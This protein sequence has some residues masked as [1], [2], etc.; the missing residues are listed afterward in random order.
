MLQ[1]PSLMYLWCCFSNKH[2]LYFQVEVPK[3]GTVEELKE[4]IKE[5][6]KDVS[7]VPTHISVA[8]TS[9]AASWLTAS[10]LF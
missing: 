2:G 9:V 7:N 5:E 6:N 8:L 3:T 4:V 10:W 1:D